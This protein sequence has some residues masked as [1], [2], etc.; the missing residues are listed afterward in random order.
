MKQT[1]RMKP[2][3]A[4][5]QAHAASTIVPDLEQLAEVAACQVEHCTIPEFLH[6]TGRKWHGD[7]I[8]RFGDK[9]GRMANSMQLPYVPA[10]NPSLGIIRSLPVPLLQWVYTQMAAQF[11]WPPMIEL[12][13]IDDEQRAQREELR[14]HEGAR[15]HLQ[16]AAEHAPTPAVADAL[17]VVM[18][19]L[20]CETERL[21]GG[22]GEPA[23]PPLHAV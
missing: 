11:G 9:A 7:E 12:N 23:T 17:A 22:S 15:K 6:R 8:M 2:A 10:V 19:W 20:D 3:R 16:S 14:R 21:R 18:N 4:T 13:A 1:N 5:R